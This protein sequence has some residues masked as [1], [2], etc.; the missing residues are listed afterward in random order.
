ML[1]RG[2]RANSV[3]RA[4]PGHS[5]ILGGDTQCQWDTTSPKGKLVTTTGLRSITTHHLP[6]SFDPYHNTHETKIDHFAIKDELNTTPENRLRVSSIRS[7]FADHHAV[8]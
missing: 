5:V 2:Q 6:P 7:S 4:H 8:K 3:I 1:L